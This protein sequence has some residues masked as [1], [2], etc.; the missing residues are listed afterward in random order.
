MSLPQLRLARPVHDPARA[1]EMYARALGLRILETFEDH[2]GFDG[3]VLGSA[4]PDSPYHFEFTRSRLHPVT[5]APTVED[6]VVLYVPDKNQWQ[7][8]CARVL[9]AGFTQVP[10]FNPYWDVRGR[11][12]QDEDGYRIV[13]ERAEWR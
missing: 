1:A 9:A 12:Y 8:M 13:L 11:S 6:L 3:V 2:D 10:A 7:T 5:P 4:A